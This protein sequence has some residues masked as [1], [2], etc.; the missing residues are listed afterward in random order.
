LTGFGKEVS[1]P[2]LVTILG[3]PDPQYDGPHTGPSWSGATWSSGPNWITVSYAGNRVYGKT[4]H[5]ASAWETL[6]WH[7]NNGAE[8][9]G[10]NWP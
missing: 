7:A 10:V 2:E 4:I 8:K 9:I 5:L 3:V 1:E 6:R